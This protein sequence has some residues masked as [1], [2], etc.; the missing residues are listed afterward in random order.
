MQAQNLRQAEEALARQNF[1]RTQQLLAEREAQLADM[2][3]R[4]EEAMHQLAE[5]EDSQELPPLE[6]AEIK[7]FL[8]SATCRPLR[9][10]R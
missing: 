3:R 8:R 6:E 9:R 7:V 5:L 2:A 1:E 10:P 4:L